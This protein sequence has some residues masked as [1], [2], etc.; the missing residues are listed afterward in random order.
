MPYTAKI[1]VEIPENSGNFFSKSGV[2]GKNPE[3][4]RSSMFPRIWDLD[5]IA[6]ETAYVRSKI[7]SNT[8]SA[9]QSNN[10]N[11][12]EGFNFEQTFKIRMYLTGDKNDY[13]IQI[14]STFTKI[15]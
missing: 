15:N 3:S 13:R 12:F 7:D 4:G 11:L 6:E 1:E 2:D 8:P 9:P 10:Q 14:D 5:R